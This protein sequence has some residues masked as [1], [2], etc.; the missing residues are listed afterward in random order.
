[1]D[2]IQQVINT[3]EAVDSNPEETE[4]YFKQKILKL[5]QEEHGDDFTT[6][7]QYDSKSLNVLANK[8]MRQFCFVLQLKIGSEDIT[9]DKVTERLIINNTLKV[10][11][12]SDIRNGMWFMDIKISMEQYHAVQEWKNLFNSLNT[13]STNEILANHL[14]I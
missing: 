5:L 6:E 12:Q 4:R 9:K 8:L 11:T 3:F 2:L 7:Y 14:E 1:M 10:S 13:T